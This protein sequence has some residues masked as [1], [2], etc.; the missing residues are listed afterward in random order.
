MPGGDLADRRKTHVL[1]LVF[2][3]ALVSVLAV[4]ALS[5]LLVSH[6]SRSYHQYRVTPYPTFWADI[7]PASGMWHPAN[8][9]F[10]HAEQCWDVTYHTNSYGARDAERS[11]RSSGR[12]RHIVLGDSFI[13]GYGLPDGDR[14]TNRL[15]ASTDQEFLNFGEGEFGTVQE[16]MLYRSLASSFEHSDVVL[17]VLPDNDFMDN[18]PKYYPRSRYRPYL[19]RTDAG[20]QIYYPVKF[21]DRD[22]HTLSVWMRAWNWLNNHVYLLNLTRQAVE[23]RLRDYVPRIYTSYEGHSKEELDTMADA[24]RGLAAAA[25]PRPVYVFMIPLQVDL[26]GYLEGKRFA[27]PDR[28]RA[29]LHDTEHVR[30]IDLLPAFLE[31]VADH[32]VPTSA[33][34]L[35]CDAHW[36]ALG[37]AVAAQAVWRQL[38]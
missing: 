3:T 22:R 26:D 7:N 19:R 29:A 10:H 30:L 17:F 21:E 35:N 16:L 8:A 27:L 11:R 9:T 25:H 12:P 32:H 34:Y 31:Y 24:I 6:G 13:E 28:L 38:H 14:L 37:N 20:D 1:I 4:E 36:G 23:H 15:N 5:R 33:F 2:G 18:D